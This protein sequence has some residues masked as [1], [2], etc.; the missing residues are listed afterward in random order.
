MNLFIGIGHGELL[1]VLQ[2]SGCLNNGLWILPIIPIA[3][4]EIGIG[5]GFGFFTGLGLLVLLVSA[6][7]I[8]FRTLELMNN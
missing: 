6:K 4:I 7:D 2:G 3:P 8:G 5:V 1:M